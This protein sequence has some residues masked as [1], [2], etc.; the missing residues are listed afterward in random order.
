M[1]S[2]FH[3]CCFELRMLVVP[4]TLTRSNGNTWTWRRLFFYLAAPFLSAALHLLHERSNK[5]KEEN[6]PTDYSRACAIR[7]ISWLPWPRSGRANRGRGWGRSRDA[8]ADDLWATGK[9]A[10]SPHSLQRTNSHG[11]GC[12]S[13]SADIHP[14]ERPTREE[15]TEKH[16]D[17]QHQ[18]P[19]IIWWS[20]RGDF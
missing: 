4:S 7:Y 6:L 5:Q 1:Q 14:Q 15:E 13:A 17:Q 9:S 8:A 10:S 16:A 18:Q 11:C 2:V 19:P 3:I 20:I 12:S